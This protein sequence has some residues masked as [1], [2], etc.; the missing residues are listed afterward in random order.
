[1]N[2]F[3]IGVR[4]ITRNRRRTLVT[5]TAMSFA[6]FV[7]VIYSALF[8]GFFHTLER[9]AVG[10][11]LADVQIHAQGYRRDPDLYLRI[12]DHEA[13]AERLEAQGLKT[14]TRLYGYGLAAAGISSAGVSFRGLDPTA[15]G[16]VTL[17][18]TALAVGQ[19]LSDEDPHGVVIGR[20]LARI[21]RVEVG[22]EVVVV[23]QAADGS[24]ANDLYRVRGILKSI[25]ETIDRAGFLMTQSAFRTLMV[26][27]EGVHEMVVVRPP[28]KMTL[29][30]AKAMVAR[31]SA[32]HETVT[33]K[34]LQPVLAQS[35]ETSIASQVFLM[36]IMYAA[37]AMLVLN[38][39]L[40]SVF[41]R[42]REFG[43]MKALGVT[44]VQVAVVVLIEVTGQAAL[45]ALFA[46]M[47]GIPLAYYLQQR[48]LDLS[49]FM[50]GTSAFGVAIHPVWY[51]LVNTRSVVF[52]LVTLIAIAFVAALY[53]GLKAA[54]FRPLEALHHR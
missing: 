15:E 3:K 31:A 22:D 8:E 1:M 32:P 38:A 7:M 53:P 23:G 17:M 26:V 19:W 25:G 50:E 54:W 18:P 46:S 45:A 13:V 21:L 27:P 14:T 34:E 49:F 10:M 4:S 47:T 12:E 42:I 9:N 2:A 28:R 35:L 52:P 43:V 24:M 29:D 41:E 37:I 36:V 51:A 48:G 44:P 11:E 6:G 39:T 16:R 30:E 40:M 5:V 33:W 20:R